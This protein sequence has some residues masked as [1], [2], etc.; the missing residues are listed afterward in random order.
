MPSTLK[1][2]FD[3]MIMDDVGKCAFYNKCIDAG[4]NAELMMINLFPKE[5]QPWVHPSYLSKG[6]APEIRSKITESYDA[7]VEKLITDK[8]IKQMADTMCNDTQTSLGIMIA[9]R[10]DNFC[11][12]CMKPIEFF[13]LKLP[14]SPLCKLDYQP[15][16]SIKEMPKMNG[17]TMVKM[18]KKHLQAL[19]YL[20]NVQD[21]HITDDNGAEMED[22]VRSDGM[23]KSVRKAEAA[24]AKAIS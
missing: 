11:Y 17:N 5:V 1:L 21:V 6:S 9:Q 18:K 7:F 19:N 20:I 4:M 24:L 10:T 12:E 8:M 14:P 3:Q 22:V 23:K 2:T 15:V 16:S 13:H